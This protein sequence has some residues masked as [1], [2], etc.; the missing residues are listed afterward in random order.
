MSGYMY[1]NCGC[2]AMGASIASTCFQC[3]SAVLRMA[4]MQQCYG[5]PQPRMG[6]FN[7]NAGQ[8]IVSQYHAPSHHWPRVEESVKPLLPQVA[9][10]AQ[11]W[12]DCS[13]A[14]KY[15]NACPY[16]CRAQRRQ[17]LANGTTL[18]ETP[19]KPLFQIPCAPQYWPRV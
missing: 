15:D 9:A 7:A 17:L 1:G 13:A 16:V 2:S 4:T 11:H 3:S 8:A 10:M 19:D 12:L 6:Y 18:M 5:Y 14:G